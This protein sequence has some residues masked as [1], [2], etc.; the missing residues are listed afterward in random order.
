MRIDEKI[1]L[2][3]DGDDAEV[4]KLV[5]GYMLDTYSGVSVYRADW[6]IDGGDV[7]SVDIVWRARMGIGGPVQEFWSK[8]VGK[9]LAVCLYRAVVECPHIDGEAKADLAGVFETA[10]D[11]SL[12]AKKTDAVNKHGWS[13]RL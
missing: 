10:V 2:L 7:F 11:A 1:K 13:R 4:F 8:Q 12:L 9:R 6:K 3:D 5:S